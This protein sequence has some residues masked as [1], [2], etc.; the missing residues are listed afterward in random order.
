MNT[1]W[2]LIGKA[3]WFCIRPVV[4][5]AAKAGGQL[6]CDEWVKDIQEADAKAK[7]PSK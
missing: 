7:E 2:I 1:T 5:R 4:K 6:L 3:V